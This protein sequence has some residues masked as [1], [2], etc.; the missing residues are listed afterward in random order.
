MKT[1]HLLNIFALC[2][3]LFF[4]LA[5]AFAQ[6][7]WQGG[8]GGFWSTGA[9]W[10][11]GVP[12]S[13]DNVLIYSDGYVYLDV[14]PTVNSLTLGGG[15][16]G[17]TAVLSDN[18]MTQTLTIAQALTVI[19]SGTLQLSSGTNVTLGADSVN[20]GHINA[21]GT[22]SISINGNFD[23]QGS[24]NLGGALSATGTFTNDGGAA[25]DG[26]GNLSLL[27]NNGY[28][29][30]GPGSTLVVTGGPLITDL[31]SL[32]DIAGI[33]TIGGGNPFA[34]LTTIEGA[35]YLHNQTTNLTP[36][37]GTLTLAD[38]AELSADSATNLTIN[39][40][41]DNSGYVST[42]GGYSTVGNTLTITGS[43]TNQANG[44]LSIGGGN[45]DTATVAGNLTN[46]GSVW[47]EGGGTLAVTGNVVTYGQF[48]TG[49]EGGGNTL[50]FT[51]LLTN[52][53][54][55]Q[56]NLYGPGD[57]L[58]VAGNVDNSG[59]LATSGVL[60][61]D[62]NVANSG[63]GNTITFTGL[64]TNTSTGQVIL[65]GPGD[66]LQ[67]RGGIANSGSISVNNASTVDPPFLNN[68]GTVNIDSTSAF[69]VGTGSPT[70]FGYIQLANGTLGEMIG[71]NAFGTITVSGPA[72]L[73]GTLDILLQGGFNPAVGSTYQIILFSPGGLT[74]IFANIQNDIFN[75]GTE[76]WKITYDNA[77]GF[78]DLTAAPYASTTPEP[79]SFLLMG[80]GLLGL[81]YSMRLR[82]N[83]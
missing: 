28:L 67:A 39:G 10:T 30:V 60:L 83:K 13:A 16:N 32:Y 4:G 31:P 18:G 14:S 65:N 12:T 50:I 71:S 62:E 5:N 23:N 59:V 36:I 42:N 68:F 72:S 46:Y 33:F 2:G 15:P 56:I 55:G 73:D 11:A 21:Y 8:N 19:P 24:L 78:V 52:T 38:S 75:N 80:T 49:G 37:G 51:G 6:N 66:L 82:L 64:L 43:V 77:N 44:A 57:R 1:S 26:G 41:L 3:V 20:A 79:T 47:L 35:L 34:S 22:S 58:Q 9:N 7:N 54:S 61:L 74:G 76:Y 29:E 45:H 48:V 17:Y 70:G 27:V 25:F 53:A 40:N 81:S 63:G 69:I